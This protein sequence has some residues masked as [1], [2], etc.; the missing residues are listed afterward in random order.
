MQYLHKSVQRQRDH[1]PGPNRPVSKTTT[2]R[3][4]VHHDIGGNRSQRH[5]GRPDENLT[6][7]QDAASIQEP[8]PLSGNCSQETRVG[9]RCVQEHEGNDQ[10]Q[11]SHNNGTC[12]PKIPQAQHDGSSD[13]KYLKSHFL[14]VL[15]GVADD[16]SMQLWNQ[17]LS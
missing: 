8:T 13:T 11:V 16:F 2:Q 7:Q 12:T 17:L 14:S 6:R 5:H 4:Q 9:K 3:N 1:L 15:V 10:I